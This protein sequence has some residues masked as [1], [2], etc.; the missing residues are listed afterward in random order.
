MAR[1]SKKK[2]NVILFK[3]FATPDLGDILYFNFKASYDAQLYKR[4]YLLLGFFF[5]TTE[6]DGFAFL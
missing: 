5:P 1:T 2:K 4:R 3:R 6:N